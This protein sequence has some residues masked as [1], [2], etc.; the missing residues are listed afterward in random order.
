MKLDKT[1]K[2][3]RTN[4][5]CLL[6]LVLFPILSYSLF[7]I[8]NTEK[9]ISLTREDSI[10]EYAGAI[11]MLLAAVFFFLSYRKDKSGSDLLIFKTK[12]N[13]F[14]L[15]LAI[16]FFIGF[17]EEISWGQRIFHFKTPA[18]ITKIADQQNEVSIH[19]L[20]VFDSR[21]GSEPQRTHWLFTWNLAR[22][23]KLFWL[24]FCL[25][26]PLVYKYSRHTRQFLNRIKLPIVPIWIGIF[27]LI[28]HSILK[29]QGYFVSK[30]L[31]AYMV[32][33]NETNISFLFLIISFYFFK[34]MKSQKKLS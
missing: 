16:I 2:P 9:V 29:A 17:A 25:L 22:L 34:E 30:E 4:L 18:F 19:N 32:E 7:F 10:M 6:A 20:K 12:K 33:V 26:I 11:S 27:F 31:R 14:F 3:S 15:L 1:E 8:P 28:N 5:I 21:E 13:V 24:S 23:I